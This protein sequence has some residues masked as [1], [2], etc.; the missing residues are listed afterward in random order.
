MWL[1]V[2]SGAQ[3]EQVAHIDAGHIPVE[4]R[5]FLTGERLPLVMA[6]YGAV[7]GDERVGA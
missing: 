5:G 4:L 7:G 3:G 2:L 6:V 1:G